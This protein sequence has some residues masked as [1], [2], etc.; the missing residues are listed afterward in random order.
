MKTKAEIA[1]DPQFHECVE[2]TAAQG[3]KDLNK[4]SFDLYFLGRFLF[5]ITSFQ[6]AFRHPKNATFELS[7][8]GQA[9]WLYF[10]E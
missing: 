7:H 2:E 8:F 1:D 3:L 4:N 6:I 10:Q 5:L 9:Q